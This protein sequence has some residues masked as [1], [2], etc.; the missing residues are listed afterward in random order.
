MG[1]AMLTIEIEADNFGKLDFFYLTLKINISDKCVP[2][3]SDAHKFVLFTQK[4]SFLLISEIS[5]KCEK[6]GV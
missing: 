5:L 6:I 1:A 2:L 3:I 4:F